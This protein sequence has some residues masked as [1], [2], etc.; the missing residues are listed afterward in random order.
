MPILKHNKFPS[1]LPDWLKDWAIECATISKNT[2]PSEDLRFHP[3]NEIVALLRVL[4]DANVAA[5][6]HAL[7]GPQGNVETMERIKT[8]LSWACFCL[9]HSKTLV[10]GTP[11]VVRKELKALAK[12]ADKLAGQIDTN[13]S[14]LWP[15]IDLSYLSE[16]AATANPAGFMPKRRAGLRSGRY[17]ANRALPD[18]VDILEAFS[19]DINEELA[20]FPKRISA[21]DG[22]NDACI[23]F[24]IRQVVKVY[25]T[26]FGRTNFEAIARLLSCLNDADISPDRIRKTENLT[27][28]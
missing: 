25:Q 4:R 27:R 8:L 7:D 17:S 18:L 20:S 6:L 22:S 2:L 15:S 19:E 3:A 13:K 5:D 12:A 1:T 24:Q 11:S 9:S 16:R 28:K 10:V 23:R 21:L 26:L 14:L